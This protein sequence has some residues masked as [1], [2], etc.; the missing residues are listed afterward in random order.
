MTFV[1]E[2]FWLWFA[3]VLLGVF[4][5]MAMTDH[6]ISRGQKGT[7][8]LKVDPKPVSGVSE[9]SWDLEA[10]DSYLTTQP[11]T[12]ELMLRN[13]ADSIHVA[14]GSSAGGLSNKFEIERLV[15]LLEHH[16]EGSGPTHR[17]AGSADSSPGGD[18][19]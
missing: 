7:G 15:G 3:F 19:Q 6:K 16:V 13:L 18:T 11:E 1:A 4:V 8:P 14:H 2:T 10:I 5:L 17:T 9:T 12:V